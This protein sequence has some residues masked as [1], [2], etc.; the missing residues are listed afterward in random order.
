VS[1][2]IAPHVNSKEADLDR[3]MQVFVAPF[4]KQQTLLYVEKFAA[5][6]A[7]NM[8]H[9]SAVQFQAALDASPDVAGLA[10]S[11]LMLFMVLTILPT[12][13]GTAETSEDEKHEVHRHSIITDCQQVVAMPGG[14]GGGGSK[15]GNM[16][17]DTRFLVMSPLD[18]LKAEG[19]WL[20]PKLRLVEVYLAFFHVW[21]RRE[22]QRGKYAHL[23]LSA[24]EL[25]MNVAAEE[26]QYLDFCR[27]LAFAMFKRGVTSWTV[28]RDEDHSAAALKANRKQQMKAKQ[29]PAKASCSSHASVVV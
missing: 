23:K 7:L 6:K 11:P 12:I 18:E 8:D 17:M 5:S 29:A 10:L 15:R 26:E 27:R 24:T 25:E 9:W 2:C 3:V 22:L 21:L 16:R 4:S 14:D 20:F 13:S 1:K 19:A 28:Q